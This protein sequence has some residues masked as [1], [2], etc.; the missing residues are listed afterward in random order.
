M[1]ID[2]RQRVIALV[3]QIQDVPYAWPGLPDAGSVREHG[4]GTC[5]SKH[6]LLAEELLSL[7]VTSTPLLVVGPLVPDGLRDT[8]DCRPGLPLVEVHECLTLIAPWAGP[9]RVDVTWD[10]VLAG[11]GL[12]ITRP[13]DG[14]SDMRLALAAGG[15]GWAVER[16]QLRAAKEAL[17]SR[18]YGPG[19]R[20]LRDR[21]LR[22]I[23]H[24]FAR[25]RA[26]R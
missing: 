26:S 17:R 24:H 15:A 19:E 23:S 6:A 4:V 21:T 20:E 10:P 1:T 3:H 5:A 22:A 12:P 25:W 8:D 2:L 16:A 11:Y 13:W 9:I 14:S 18:L 7:G